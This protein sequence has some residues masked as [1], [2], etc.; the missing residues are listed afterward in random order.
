MTFTKVL[1]FFLLGTLSISAQKKYVTL[2]NSEVQLFVEDFGKGQP[3]IFIP[4]WTMSTQFFQNQREHYAKNYRYISYD[5]RSQGKSTKTESGNT[6]AV[7]AKDLKHLMEALKLEK[8]ILVG[9]SSGCAAVFEFVAQYGTQNLRQ[10]V[11]IDEPPKWI[12]DSSNEWV[13]GSFDGYRGSLKELL[14]DPKAYSKAVV[15]WMLESEITEEQEAWMI[16]EIMQTPKYAALS[17]YIDG[18]IS[19][20]NQTVKLIDGQIPALYMVRDSWYDNT[21]KWLKNNAPQAKCVAISSHAMFWEKP[22]EF[23]KLLDDFLDSWEN[24]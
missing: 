8:P 16:G 1:L 3:I 9:W 10:V 19:D 6:Y 24:K 21:S 23:N 20:Y 18:L 4:G 2:P 22:E 11:L 5:P 13:Y 12:G 17:L 15:D 14:H 7:H